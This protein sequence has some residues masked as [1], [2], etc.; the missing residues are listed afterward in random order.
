MNLS[1]YAIKD[2]ERLKKDIDKEIGSRR[3]HEE[4]QARD[5]LKEVAAKYGF[6]LNELLSGASMPKGGS[7]RKQPDKFRHP[8]DPS[9]TWT[10]RGRKPN[11]VKAWEAAGSSINDLTAA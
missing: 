3:K 4:K 1:K 2:L 5:E 9:K 11:W 6:T 7:Q 10:G 8:D